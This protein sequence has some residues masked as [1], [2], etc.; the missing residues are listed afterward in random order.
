M[1][2]GTQALN[3]N[4]T[5]GNNMAMGAQTAGNVTTGSLNTAVGGAALLFSTVGQ[6]NTSVGAGSNRGVTSIIATL[7]I[8]NPGSGYTDG[9]YTNV[10]LV[11]AVAGFN[12]TNAKATVTISGGQVA[13]VTITTD[14]NCHTLQT[15]TISNTEVGGTGSGF[16]GTAT[17]ITTGEFNTAIGSQAGRSNITGSRNVFIGYNAGRN[18]TGSDNLYISNHLTSTP[19]IYGKFDSTGSTGGRVKINGN[20]EIK[21]KTPASAT[22]TGVVGEIAWDADY[23]Y[24]CIATNTWRRIQHQSW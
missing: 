14:G 10:T 24:V 18:E 2:V 8:T 23:F 6:H 17:A 1:A 9:T 11:P 12:Q 16:I 21:G 3:K 15:Y 4:T 22:D 20:L 13:T 19:L 7:A 5:G